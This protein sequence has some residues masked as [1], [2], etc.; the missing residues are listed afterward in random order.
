MERCSR[1][2][3]DTSGKPRSVLRLHAASAT[4]AGRIRSTNQDRALL[5]ADLIAV[6]D[7]MGGHAGG[8]VAAE[9]AVDGLGSSYDLTTSM[10]GLVAAAKRANRAIFLKSEADA[11][12]HGMGTTLT[13]AALVVSDTPPAL[14]L[15]NIGDSRAYIL[16]E[17]QF[18]QI[19]EDHSFVEH[20]VRQGEI[21]P[22][23]A[24]THPHRHILTRAV[25]IE[26]EVDVDAFSFAAQ[27]GVRVLLASDG[28]T[29]ELPDHEIAA[30]L[31][32]NPDRQA[33]ADA[34]VRAA[35]AHGGNDNVTVVVADV[36]DDDLEAS[37]AAAHHELDET[38]AVG[39]PTAA[40][41]ALADPQP[42][43][44]PIPEALPTHAISAPAPT[45]RREISSTPRGR[46]N[47]RRI[48]RLVTG[49]V[50]LF[51]VVLLGLFGGIIG[52]TVWFN[53]ASYFVGV[54]SGYV[55]I[56]EGRPGGFLWFKPTITRV[57][58][59]PLSS[60]LDSSRSLLEAGLLEPSYDKAQQVVD[61]LTNENSILGLPTTTTTT[62]I[63][64]TT[65]TSAAKSTATTSTTP[66]HG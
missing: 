40:A 41:V 45:P 57:T 42:E 31:E 23:E 2:D 25:G 36:Q 34:L 12:L 18:S 48:E 50:L 47:L 27:P 4:D 59:L 37:T 10:E 63:F 44:D 62:T 60:V 11:E 1:F 51:V 54:R 26:S 22:E 13:A 33:A 19:S 43:A 29:N 55:T 65:T 56:Y 9:L 15:I 38:R 53:R 17:H 6:A 35:L 49:R 5:G 8:E 20:L 3:D 61:S 30:I 21:T 64:V 32:A 46:R 28:L 14:H 66:G 24:L 58:N 52:F 7:G 16:H 39:D